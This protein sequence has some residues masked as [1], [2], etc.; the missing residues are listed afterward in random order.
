MADIRTVGE[1]LGCFEADEKIGRKEKPHFIVRLLVEN[2]G[3]E[4]VTF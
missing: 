4:P 2:T 3:I 1:K